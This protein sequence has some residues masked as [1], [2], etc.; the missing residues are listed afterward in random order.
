LL[1]TATALYFIWDKQAVDVPATNNGQKVAIVELFGWPYNDV[2]NECEFLG[3]AGWAGVRIW[4]AQGMS[5]PPCKDY[6]R[7]MTNILYGRKNIWSATTIM[8]QMDNTIR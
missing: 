7:V 6:Q 4:P 3:K 5:K 2:A 1:F 8:K